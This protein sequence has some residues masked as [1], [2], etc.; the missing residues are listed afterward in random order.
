MAGALELPVGGGLS[1]AERGGFARVPWRHES[2]P[3]FEISV[4]APPDWKPDELEQMQEKVD[5]LRMTPLAAFQGPPRGGAVPVFVVEALALAREVTAANVLVSQALP[6]RWKL[7]AM[8]EESPFYADSLWRHEVEGHAFAARRVA[9]LDGDRVFMSTGTAPIGQAD[10]F[11]ETF[12]HMAASMTPT[13]PSEHPRQVQPRE[14]TSVLDRVGFERPK[15]WR[16]RP[17]PGSDERRA[18]VDLLGYDVVKNVGGIMRVEVDLDAGGLDAD[19]EVERTLSSWRERGMNISGD[20]PTEI[21]V[22]PGSSPLFPV[23]CRIYEASIDNNDIPQEVWV[24][25]LEHEGARIRVSLGTASRRGSFG[26]WAHN[27]RAYRIALDTMQ[28]GA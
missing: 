1:D 25:V 14:R 6:A 4:A 5:L 2:N 7:L 21:A 26:Y 11:A 9:R 27:T 13:S 3:R 16:P 8:R 18:A 28:P 24:T 19:A 10:H 23:A 22:A 15:T 12:G 20:E 17:V